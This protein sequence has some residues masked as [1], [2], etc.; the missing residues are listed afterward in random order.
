MIAVLNLQLDKAAV[1][2]GRALD[3]ENNNV[4]QVEKAV[5]DSIV[6]GRVG[7]LKVDPSYLYLD[8]GKLISQF[9]QRPFSSNPPLQYTIPDELLKDK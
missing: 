7:A 5:K 4:E 3:D 1:E 9:S 8:S 2:R 6:T